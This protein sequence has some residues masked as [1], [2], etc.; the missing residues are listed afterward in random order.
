[1]RLPYSFHG[2]AGVTDAVTEVEIT[3]G[4][5]SR[6]VKRTSR[7][8]H[9]LLDKVQMPEP[10]DL[11]DRP[12][13]T[14]FLERSAVSFGASLISGRA[15]T[16]K[17]YAGRSFAK[18]Y[19]SVAWYTI[20][21]TDADWY[22]FAN[23]L[24]SAIAGSG[25]RTDLAEEQTDESIANFVA[26]LFTAGTE[27]FKNDDALIILDDL[28]HVF[29]AAWFAP[30]FTH[31]LSSIPRNMHLLILCRSKPPLPLWRL[32]SKQVLNVIDEK[33]LAFDAA[34]TTSLCRTLGVPEKMSMMV[35]LATFG[36]AGK[37]ADFLRSG[38]VPASNPPP[39]NRKRP[40][41]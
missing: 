3:T 21:S 6:P 17:T 14:E 37:V 12:R 34:D 35:P 40:Y 39:R 2:D 41:S 4:A 5:P 32:R 33:V 1:M 18:T 27:R 38:A 23:Y 8:L 24:W 11:V 7:E 22:I 10:G 19:R 15:I 28:H 25:G 16:G 31:L 20:D 36:R 13:I 26:E 9:L 30:F 29:D